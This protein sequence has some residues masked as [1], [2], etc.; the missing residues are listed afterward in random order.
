MNRT[1]SL[2]PPVSPDTK[3]AGRI[4]LGAGYRLPASVPAEIADPGRIRFG[5]G[6]RLP[7]DR[8]HA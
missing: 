7:A 8:R 5:A 6:Y 4:R 2:P 1:K 3:D